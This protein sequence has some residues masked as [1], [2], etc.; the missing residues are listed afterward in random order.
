M[1]VICGILNVLTWG[2]LKLNVCFQKMTLTKLKKTIL[3]FSKIVWIIK[4]RHFGFFS[5]KMILSLEKVLLISV[6]F[7]FNHSRVGRNLWLLKNLFEN[8]S[9]PLRSR[10]AEEHKT[11]RV[12][13]CILICC[14]NY[15]SEFLWSLK[16]N[17]NWKY[18]HCF[19]YSTRSK[20]AYKFYDYKRLLIA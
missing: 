11:Y 9:V 6:H 19:F 18:N 20:L 12:Q 17:V 10:V 16:P 1:S 5:M 7:V 13:W 8:I 4:L 14:L 15:S 2:V 3:I